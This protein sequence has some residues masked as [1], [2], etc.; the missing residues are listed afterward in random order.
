MVFDFAQAGDMVAIVIVNG[1][2]AAIGTLL[3]RLRGFGAS[4]IS[5][6]GGVAPELARWFDD[7][8]VEQLVPPRG[9]ALDGA[10]IMARQAA[11]DL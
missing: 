1:A 10:I 7:A 9:D 8:I 11:G 5:L 2:T 3:G 4:Q 6:M